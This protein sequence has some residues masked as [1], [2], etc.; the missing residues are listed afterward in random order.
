MERTVTVQ[1]LG[2]RFLLDVPER[3]RTWYT[4]TG[5]EQL[6]SAVVAASVQGCDLFIDV[7]AHVGY[8]SLVALTAAPS[9][10]VV[11]I[12]PSPDA[13]AVLTANLARADSTNVT[14]LTGV[15]GATGVRASF[16]VTEA[17]DNCGLFGHPA[18]PTLATIDVPVITS[19]DL[20]DPAG[21]TVFVKID[22]EGAE[23]LVL[24]SIAEYLRRAASVR[25]LVEL[26]P[27]CLSRAGATVSDVLHR[28]GALNLRA[29][30]LNEHT[31]DLQPVD[32]AGSGDDLVPIGYRNLYCLPDD[33]LLVAAVLHSGEI[34]GAQLTHAES[35]TDMVA[36]GHM[37][38]TA[39]PGENAPLW[40]VLAAAG[41][42]LIS[43]A[44]PHWWAAVDEPGAWYEQAMD[45]DLIAQV[46]RLRPDVIVS[47]TVA[48]T[49]GAI[50]AAVTLT[51]H[52][53]FAHEFAD[54]DHGLHLASEAAD[55]GW[56]MRSLSAEVAANASAVAEHFWPG[57]DVAVI[58]SIPSKFSPLPHV[59]SDV[60]R[61]LV[62]GTLGAAKGQE[63]VVAALAKLVAGGVDAR[64]TLVGTGSDVERERLRRQLGDL[65]LVDR[66]EVRDPIADRATLFSDADVVIVASRN[67]AFGRVA[68]EAAIAGLP[69]IYTSAGGLA[70]EMIADV[71]G[72]AV[73]P[74][75]VP[76]LADAIAQLVPSERRRVLAES[77]LHA[78]ADRLDRTDRRRIW[79]D[80]LRR[81]AGAPPPPLA[82][83]LAAVTSKPQLDALVGQR[84]AALADV[85]RALEQR[86]EARELAAAAE[87]RLTAAVAMR[88]DS[89][90]AYEAIRSSTIWRASAP[91][92]RLRDKLSGR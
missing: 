61:L 26:N 19:A 77:A 91:Y 55:V 71:T 62:V 11:A 70:D 32:L 78:L 31:L 54:R 42:A 9:I 6:T 57:K 23:A 60:L 58:R 50:A 27:R 73:E 22:V 25:L 92:R 69:L 14:I 65:N 63:Y 10:D 20:P 45:R 81:A 28:I 4:D 82:M 87:E 84:A 75:D 79:D 2:R 7:G 90:A 89:Q 43:L 36:A 13:A 38:V 8:L 18:S 12:E 88:D 3:N 86:D 68:Y 33:S 76:G 51:P 48:I 52:I 37:V 67:E 39:M 53:W 29:Y 85:T 1:P 15:M 64:L 49:Q 66:V 17:S 72:L 80:L 41:G 74:G 34:G 30:L 24:D 16:D 47:R 44:R 46:E 21:K 5:Y 40:P 83:L 59:P 56:L 35:V